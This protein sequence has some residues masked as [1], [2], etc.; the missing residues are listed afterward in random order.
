MSVLDRARELGAEILESSELLE[1]RNAEQV[2]LNDKE[3][4]KLIQEFK[5]K[6]K[7]YQMIKSK[8]E[9]LTESQQ[10]E[11]DDLESRM[12]DNP[13]ILDYFRAQQNFENMLEEINNI[14]AGAIS[15]GECQCADDCCTSCDS[16]CNH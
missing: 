8:G 13:L 9:E 11:V 14:I 6:Q 16:E 2:M 1:M 7:D 10:Q 5:D 12:L 15:G 4:Q 3:A